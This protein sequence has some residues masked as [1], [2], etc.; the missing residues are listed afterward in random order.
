MTN[1]SVKNHTND[2]KNKGHT[3]LGMHLPNIDDFFDKFTHSWPFI[4][5]SYA[6]IEST[7]LTLNPKVDITED[8][9]SY[10]MSAELPGLT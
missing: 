6:S 2:G 9:K 7:D 4:R 10:K 5:P 3:P 8:G 1:I